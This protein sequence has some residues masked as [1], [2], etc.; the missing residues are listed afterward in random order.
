MA[1]M[2]EVQLINIP[3]L[4]IQRITLNIIGDTGLISHAWAD[5][6]IKEIQGKQAG[7]PKQGREK[8]DPQGDYA[9]S[10]YWLDKKGNL[11]K[12]LNKDPNE[13]G[14]FG[15]KTIAF[16]AAAITAANDVGVKMT[17]ARR[18]FRVLGEYVPLE[19]DRIEFRTDSV[20]IGMGTTD[21]RYR[22]E[23]VNWK[24]KLEIEYNASIVNAAQI[25]NL[26]NTAGFGVGV[27]E[28]RPQRNGINGCY[29]IA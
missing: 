29:H 1:K 21:L 8:R 23:F 25:T 4:K 28:W 18:W 6:A 3:A 10:L 16:K 24:C 22:G 13:H 17:E 2:K 14:M 11:I 15:F 27:G 19:F 26:F 7:A 12:P 5:K 20:K 9:S